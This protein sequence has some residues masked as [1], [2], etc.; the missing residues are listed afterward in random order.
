MIFV[1]HPQSR[2]APGIFQ[3]WIEREAVVLQR[4]RSAMRGDFHRAREIVRQGGLVIL[5]PSRRSRREAAHP[6]S[7]G[8]EIDSRVK[9]APAIEAHL[10]WIQFV[11]IMQHAADGVTFVFVEG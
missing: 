9:P 2:Q 11:E 8:R 6:K 3:F 1:S 7:Y 10:L 5:A 4:Q